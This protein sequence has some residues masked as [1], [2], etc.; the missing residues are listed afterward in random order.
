MREF[1]KGYGFLAAL[2]AVIGLAFALPGWGAPGGPLGHPLPAHIGIATIFLSLGLLLRTESLREDLRDWRLHLLVQ[3]QLFILFPLLIV[4]ILAAAGDRIPGPLHPGLLLLAVLPTTISTC[5]VFTMTAGG[6]TA[7]SVFNSTLSSLVGVLLAPIWMAWRLSGPSGAFP[8]LLPAFERIGLL[9][10][11][12]LALGQ[13]L[14]PRLGTHARNHRHAITR[15]NNTIILFLVFRAFSQSTGAGMW[16]TDS[17][18]PVARAAGVAAITFACAACF[19]WSASGW[20]GLPRP[21]RVTALFCASQKSLATAVAL[22]APLWSV[23]PAVDPSLALVPILAYAV[24][25][26]AVGGILADRMRR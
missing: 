3:G 6:N 5:N 10:I 2:A 20:L 11:L 4:A 15:L 18:G 7:A 8:T 17:L 25:Q 1:F 19:A 16:T 14:R 24:I 22:S 23:F 26:L 21:S 9:V 12:P 13:L